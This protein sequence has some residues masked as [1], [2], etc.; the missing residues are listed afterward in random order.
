MHAVQFMSTAAPPELWDFVPWKIICCL[1]V[2]HLPILCFTNII[3]IS[4]FTL[5]RMIDFGSV[6][7]LA[8]VFP[9]QS[10]GTLSSENIL[11]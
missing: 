7:F 6:Y 8:F 1:H 4:N 5:F 10:Y 11:V 9:H 2:T 3:Q